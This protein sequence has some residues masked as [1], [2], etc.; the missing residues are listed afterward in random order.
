[1]A[2]KCDCGLPLDP[3]A[4]GDY[5]WPSIDRPDA[6]VSTVVRYTEDPTYRRVIRADG[7]WVE[8]GASVDGTGTP[9]PIPW[10]RVGTCWADTKHPVVAVKDV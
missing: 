6:D 10:E 1:V 2:D 9:G 3:P 8:R 7:G 4:E 5:Y